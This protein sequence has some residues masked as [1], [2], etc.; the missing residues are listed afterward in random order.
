MGILNRI[1]NVLTLVFAL[2]ILVC[3]VFL[4]SKRYQLRDRG[5]RMATAIESASKILDDK[6]NTVVAWASDMKD[7]KGEFKSEKYPSE[8]LR[9]VRLPLKPVQPGSKGPGLTEDDAEENTKSTL[10]HDNYNTPGWLLKKKFPGGQVPPPE[11]KG[12]NLQRQLDLFL[13]QAK[14]IIMQRDRLGDTLKAIADKLCLPEAFEQK[15]FYSVKTYV[16]ND[17]KLVAFAETVNK[18]NDMFVDYFGRIGGKI[19]KEI[20]QDFKEKSRELKF[21]DLSAAL[22][23][24]VTDAEK[25]KKR[26]DSYA[27][28]I[29]KMIQILGLASPSAKELLEEDY[30]GALST[31]ENGAKEVKGDLEKTKAELA[32]T[33]QE[34]DDTRQQLADLEKKHAD[35]TKKYEV[36]QKD[37][38]KLKKIIYGGDENVAATDEKGR[39]REENLYSQLVGKV[40]DVN[41]KWDFVV[42]DLGKNSKLKRMM[43]NGKP[44]ELKTPLPNDK[45]MF[46][47]RGDQFIA[48]IKIV[49]VS[50]NCSI[51]N[52][53]PGPRG[54]TVEIGDKVFFP[55]P[56][57]RRVEEG[58]G[59]GEGGGA[60][61]GGGEG[62]GGAPAGA[63]AGGVDVSLN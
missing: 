61:A 57:P 28:T 5:D 21:D 34:L 25:L 51:A 23:K 30:A 33:K 59:G 8:R 16:E 7:K 35:L 9:T 56:P 4:F 49:K 52:I 50:D 26:S 24:L 38:A 46:V 6:D 53:T 2:A 44:Q 13:A 14:D 22:D 11:Y 32:R 41:K 27:N 47:S 17:Q 31:A 18:R 3:G 12:A 37:I 60:P 45:E 39:R 63:E 43:K 20:A 42:I 15:Q 29:A 10:F 1:V 62:G 19:K 48:K 55:P 40:V 58:A 36:S 54:G